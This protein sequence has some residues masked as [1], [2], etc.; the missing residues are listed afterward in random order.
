MGNATHSSDRLGSA[1]LG[2]VV[3]ARFYSQAS[4]SSNGPI[5]RG[6]ITSHLGYLD[7]LRAVAAVYVVLHHA[8]MVAGLNQ[9]PLSGF[10]KQFAL[11]FFPGRY[12]VDLFIVLSGF[13][14]ML[15]VAKGDGTIHNG[16]RAFYFRR[17][18]RILPPYYAAMFLSL[19]LIWLL[20]NN[21]TGSSLWDDSIPVTIKSV[22]THLFLIHDA[23]GDD[24]SINPVFWSIAVE[25]RIYFLFPILVWS[26]RRAGP[27]I[28]TTAALITSYILLNLCQRFIGSSLSAHYIGLFAMGMLGATM[29]FSASPS[30]DRIARLPWT[31]LAGLLT[32]LVF[33]L[34]RRHIPVLSNISDYVVGLWS[35]SLIAVASLHPKSMFRAILDYRPIVFIGTFAYSIYLIHAPLLQIFRQYSLSRFQDSPWT[36]FF[37]LS[38][39]G[40]PAIVA[41][42]YLFFL[43]FE[44]PFLR[45]RQAVSPEPVAVKPTLEPAL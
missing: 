45:K 36:M 6:Q 14:I 34:S 28:T 20:L 5:G 13:C 17:A 7:G 9:I 8:L 25:W 31:W 4:P 21:K 27:A 37:L 23:F 29:V 1:A 43:A 39:I 11:L 16:I 41:I 44:R 33:F 10:S 18:R 30:S 38:L 32:I 42:S 26:W 2:E 3:H 19:L 24:H 40:T 15:P 35:L 22:V 12:A